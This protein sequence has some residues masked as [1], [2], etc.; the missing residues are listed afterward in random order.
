MTELYLLYFSGIY[1]IFAIDLFTEKLKIHVFRAVASIFLTSFIFYLTIS[2]PLLQFFP[3]EFVY[4]L[5][6]FVYLKIFIHKK[7]DLIYMYNP[8]LMINIVEKFIVFFR[9]GIHVR[10]QKL[11]NNIN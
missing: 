9:A 2:F 10:L 11:Y 7:M 8:D 6:L 1:S 3:A 4:A 5:V